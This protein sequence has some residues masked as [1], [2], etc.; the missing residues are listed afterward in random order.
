MNIQT[1]DLKT[2][3]SRNFLGGGNN[4]DQIKTYSGKGART[5]KWLNSVTG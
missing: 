3:L 1:H 4:N 5:C 2:I